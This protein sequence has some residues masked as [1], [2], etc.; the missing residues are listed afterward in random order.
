MTPNYLQ[1][2][3]IGTPNTDSVNIQSRY[4]DGIWQKECAMLTMKSGKR[5]MAEEI[6]LPNQ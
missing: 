5:L 2:T 6:Q 3:K 1:K 4:M